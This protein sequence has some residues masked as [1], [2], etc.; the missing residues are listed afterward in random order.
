MTNSLEQPE[1]IK[2]TPDEQMQ[3]VVDHILIYGSGS[4]VTLLAEE[5]A[6][7]KAKAEALD[8]LEKIVSDKHPTVFQVYEM[9]GANGKK[10]VWIDDGR[11]VFGEGDN[12]LQ[13]I[14]NLKDK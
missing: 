4:V 10:E 13:A 7:L 1:T 11:H 5:Y 12:L 14:S 2:F 8:K 6:E 9:H 3:K